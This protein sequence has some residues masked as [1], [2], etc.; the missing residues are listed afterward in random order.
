MSQPKF[1]PA[2]YRALR[3]QGFSNRQIAALLDVDEASVR[4]GLKGTSSKR[5]QRRFVVTVEEVD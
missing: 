3:D 4:R 1:A 5:S 2:V